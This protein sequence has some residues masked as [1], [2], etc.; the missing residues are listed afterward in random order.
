MQ[1]TPAITRNCSGDALAADCLLNAAGVAR[2]PKRLPLPVT[3]IAIAGCLMISP[4]AHGWGLK[5]HEMQARSAVAALPSAMPAFFRGSSEELAF[6]ITEPDRWRTS[7][8]R[9][10]NETT[11]TNH[12]FKVELNPG[13]LP[14]NRHLFIIAKAKDPSFDPAKGHTVRDFGTAPYAIQEWA[15][16]LTGA[17]R[18]WRAMPEGTP[19]DATRK[20]MHEK[21]ILF[22]AGVLGHWVTDVSQPMHS[23]YHNSGWNP[24][25]ANPKGYAGKNLHPRYETTYV[26][27]A[28]ELTDVA[29]LVGTKARLLAGWLMEAQKYCIANNQHVEQIYVWDAQ[30]PFGEGGEPAEAKPFTAARLADGARM[31]RDVWY[32]AWVRSG[33]PLP[34][35]TAL[36]R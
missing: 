14:E 26:D 17:F 19:A 12:T 6:L 24:K 31:L 7:E 32:T 18:R 3:A 9:A 5:G 2:P 10:L 4:V 20:R 33:A 21:S 36:K 28:I 1:S 29:P 8:Q 34:L 25:A 16:M 15:E 27:R 13:A 35:E 11:G 30:S 22:M 23:S